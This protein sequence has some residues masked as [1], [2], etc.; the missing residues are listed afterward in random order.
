MLRQ[1]PLINADIA[2]GFWSR[3]P[4][5]GRKLSDLLLSLF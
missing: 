1:Y 2:S 4:Q 5:L 3:W